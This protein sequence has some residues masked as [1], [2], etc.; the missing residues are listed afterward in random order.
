MRR[1]SATSLVALGLCL[2]LAVPSS[3]HAGPRVVPIYLVPRDM[4]PDTA[5]IRLL[6]Q[7]LP[8]VRQ[9]YGR[10]N[11]GPTY[12]DDP[13]I[14]QISGYSFAEFA[15]DSFQAWWP[16]LQQEFK[17]YGVDWE[18]PDTKLLFIAHGAGAW[19]GSD[20]RNGGIDSVAEAGLVADGDSGGIAVVGDS[21]VAG[22]LAGVCPDSGRTGTA[23]WCSWYTFEGTLA[24]E[25]GHT[26]GLPHPDAF[27]KGF[28]CADSTAWTNMQCHWGFPFDS[29]LPY[30][31]KHLRS[32]RYFASRPEPP[33]RM[34]TA[35][36][37]IAGRGLV[38]TIRFLRGEGLLW[39]DGRAGGTGYPWG[40]VVRGEASWRI[41]AG[42]S[43]FAASLGLPRDRPASTRVRI[44]L[45]GTTVYQRELLPG[46]VPL[47]V[48][49]PV[50]RAR[51][52]TIVA[53]GAVGVGNGRWIFR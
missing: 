8:A 51:Q 41:P 4:T 40:S 45:D 30:E 43:L 42:D 38:R 18:D 49:L 36:A 23:W 14:V 44:R 1:I 53:D 27:L 37:P 34:L 5:G 13:L 19:A 33:Y 20:S 39:M 15:A 52:L 46:D 48:V 28:R 11:H 3:T 29:L 47:P 2:S 31:Q 26:F 24:H 25:L 10:A 35:E 17:Q 9:W 32:L 21:S 12:L 50:G 6:L 22:Y 7:A 16:L